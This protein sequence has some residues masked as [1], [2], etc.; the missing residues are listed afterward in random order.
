MSHEL[1]TPLNA[2]LGFSQLLYDELT[3]AGHRRDL[4]III[5]SGEHLL[6]LIN[7]VLDVAKI[8]AGHSELKIAPVDLAG[9][10]EDIAAM[11]HV[12][13]VEQG[14]ELVVVR[15]PEVPRYVRTDSAKLRQVLINL[16]GNAIKF[17]DQ[18]AIT[19]RVGVRSGGDEPECIVLQFEIEDTG[20]GVAPEDQAR[21]FEPFE[22]LVNGTRHKGTGLGLAIARQLVTLMGGSLQLES[23]LGRGSCFRLELPA[24]RTRKSEVISAPPAERV[25]G[26]EPGQPAH[27]V[28]I[29]EDEAENWMVLERMLQ[30]AGFDVRVAENG[31]EGVEVFKEWL[32]RFIWMDLRMP[33]MDGVE[34]TRRIRALDGGL[35]VKIAAVTASGFESDRA[36]V[37]SAG[38]D[39]YVRKP[40]RP[41]EIFDC[42]SRHLGVRFRRAPCETPISAESVE[43]PR[44]AMAN[45]PPALR[46][47]LREAILALNPE[48]ISSVIA[49]ADA[50]DPELGRALTQHAEM[51]SYAAILDAIDGGA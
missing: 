16:L 7:D 40:Y 8:E 37:L 13:A 12:R 15:S 20:I 27:R 2:I 41:N 24:Q 51:F 39:D 45:L 6:S 26:L 22:Q 17:T 25:L 21:I 9:T 43:L 32:P 44:A 14:L 19:L 34:A 29:V 28:L 35:D 42:L 10:V 48:L 46:D 47:Q 5:R 30:N 4:D 11:M 18:G 36:D 38:L 31:A 3:C 49:E 23:K 50:H 33:V 1:R